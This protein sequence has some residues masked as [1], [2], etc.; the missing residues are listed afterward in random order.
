MATTRRPLA[1]GGAELPSLGAIPSLCLVLPGSGHTE[2]YSENARESRNLGWDVQQHAYQA[3]M[4]MTGVALVLGPGPACPAPYHPVRDG[5]PPVPAAP[6][7]ADRHREAGDAV[8]LVVGIELE[9]QVDRVVD[10]ADEG[11]AGAGL[12]VYCGTILQAPAP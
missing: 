11:H 9:L 3:P 10:A 2:S 4:Q 5:M 6:A 7:Q 8:T 12:L 1:A